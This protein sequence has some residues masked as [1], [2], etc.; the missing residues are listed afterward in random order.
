[1]IKMILIK[2]LFFSTEEKDNLSLVN[3]NPYNLGND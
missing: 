2:K 1:M 3:I